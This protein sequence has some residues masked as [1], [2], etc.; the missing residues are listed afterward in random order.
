VSTENVRRYYRGRI[1]SLKRQHREALNHAYAKLA[2]LRRDYSLLLTRLNE[3]HG[4]LTAEQRKLIVSQP[5]PPLGQGD[6]IKTYE[7]QMKRD[8]TAAKRGRTLSKAARAAIRQRV[9][10]ADGGA[11]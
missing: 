6:E 1:N 4:L 5:P 7:R 10:Y 3:T 2:E 9:K 8:G 11:R